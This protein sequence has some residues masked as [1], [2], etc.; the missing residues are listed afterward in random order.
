M[1]AT[2]RVFQWL[3]K[4][5]NK[6]AI[7]YVRVSTDK[8]ANRGVSL[9]AQ[10]EKIDRSGFGDW[11]VRGQRLAKTTRQLLS[12]GADQRRLCL[13]LY[14]THQADPIEAVANKD[15]FA[16]L[17]RTNRLR[18]DWKGHVGIVGPAEH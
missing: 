12:A 8:Q 14:K 4:Y 11:V 5:E 18:N 1:S 15:L 6:S 9:E 17:E 16:V 3:L 7:G 2:F 10:V 13:E